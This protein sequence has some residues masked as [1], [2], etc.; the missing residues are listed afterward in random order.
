[1]TTMRCDQITVESVATLTTVGYGE[2]FRV[3]IGGRLIAVGIMLSG[4][5]IIGA[6][7]AVVAFA[8]AGRLAQRLEAA[9]SQVENQGRG[10]PRS[11][12]RAGSPS[13]V[14]Q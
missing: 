9:V 10:T 4:I 3:T 8:F 1:M 6:V 7:A 2:H 11:A 5:G 13:A 14:I 12:S